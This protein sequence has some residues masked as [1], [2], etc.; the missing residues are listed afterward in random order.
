MSA[1]HKLRMLILQCFVC[2]FVCVYRD[3]DT[4]L[5]LTVILELFISSLSES[6][7]ISYFSLIV[8]LQSD[9]YEDGVCM[10]ILVK[11]GEISFLAGFV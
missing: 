9:I 8:I 5:E 4:E 11:H 7:L 6:S 3:L 1:L 10:Y 2:L